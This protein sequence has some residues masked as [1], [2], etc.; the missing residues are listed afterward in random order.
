LR[1]VAVIMT[2]GE[3]IW[4]C[5]C[6]GTVKS[7]GAYDVKGAMGRRKRWCLLRWWIAGQSLPCQMWPDDPQCASL[8]QAIGD[9][10]RPTAQFTVAGYTVR[11][12]TFKDGTESPRSIFVVA[13]VGA[14]AEENSELLMQFAGTVQSWRGLRRQRSG[15]VGEN[16]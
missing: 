12:R 9:M 8:A 4:V 15:W 7:G 3:T 5:K 1:R 14:P 6:I 16:T 10:R 11:M 13:E 2:E